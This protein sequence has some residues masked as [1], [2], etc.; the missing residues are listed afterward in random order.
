ATGHE[1]VLSAPHPLGATV[2]DYSP[3]GIYLAAPGEAGETVIRLLDPR[4]GAERL[5]TSAKIVAA[6]A[7]GKVWLSRLTHPLPGSVY[8]D[9]LTAL[10][11]NTGSER[12][13]FHQDNSLVG[14]MGLTSGM[15]PGVSISGK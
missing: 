4:K 8:A 3:G 9:T 12:A 6:V 1:R 11:L 7:D 13:W 5:L 14:L 10:D 2:F 15:L